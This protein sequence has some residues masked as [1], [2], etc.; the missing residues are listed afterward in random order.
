MREQK[1]EKV[2]INIL[3]DFGI[4]D[5]DNLS[6]KKRS[7]YYMTLTQEDIDFF[8]EIDDEEDDEDWG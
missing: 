4:Y 6:P 8:N 7:K 3:E 5:G 2:E 1:E